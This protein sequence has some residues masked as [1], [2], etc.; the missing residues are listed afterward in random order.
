MNILVH[1]GIMQYIVP[2]PVLYSAVSLFTHRGVDGY[3]HLSITLS[4]PGY[5]NFF[6]E[7]NQ[8]TTTKAADENGNVS[9][10]EMFSFV[11]PAGDDGAGRGNLVLHVLDHHTFLGDFS[12]SDNLVVSIDELKVAEEQVFEKMNLPITV[13][14]IV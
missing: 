11:V 3:V 7:I 6:K 8:V 14:S 9:W 2:S 4:V 10:N 5:K 1:A 13:I 12:C